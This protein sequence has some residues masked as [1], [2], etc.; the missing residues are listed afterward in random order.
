MKR[1]P[2]VA[3]AFYENDPEALKKRIE[4]C[5]KH[6]IGPG[7]LPGKPGGERLS[8]GVVSPHAGYIYSGPVAA[9]S[10]LQLS[11]EKAP[12]TLV[13]AGPNHTG[14]GPLVS[15]MTEGVW[16]TP[17]GEVE[18]DKEL[19][20]ELVRRSKYAEP[21]ASAHEY[22][23]SVEVQIPFLQYV[24]KTFKI[25]PI[26]FYAQMPETS[27]DIAH[28]L[29]EA[30]SHL[31]KDYIFIASSDMSH[32]VPYEMAYKRDKIAIDAILE[33]DVHRLYRV[34]EEYNI[35]MCGPGPVAALMEL[36]K[37]RNGK[38]PRLL[39]YA[40]SGDVSGDKISVVGYASIHFPL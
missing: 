22:E 20:M 37:I 13:I 35:S 6:E 2:A 21:D 36:A 12:E 1:H 40:T 9:H 15:V 7:S 16:V 26:V 38:T 29:N 27:I 17:L 39:K 25:V 28:A 8:I 3:G 31:D 23:H 24:F 4:W 11:K 32:Y 5:F 18:I 33:L 34:L 10:Y 30:A 14:I 19:A